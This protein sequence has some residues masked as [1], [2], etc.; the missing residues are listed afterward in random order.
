MAANADLETEAF[1]S[2]PEMPST[3]AADSEMPE[4]L[5]AL[6]AETEDI[7]AEPLAPDEI[8]ASIQ[9]VPSSEEADGLSVDRAVEMGLSDE[10]PEIEP[11]E[12]P[13]WLA[14]M[15]IDESQIGE[16]D[17]VEAEIAAEEEIDLEPGDLPD[18]LVAMALSLIHI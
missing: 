3:E 17:R 1:V 18:W 10:E 7:T 4:W 11:G 6:T 13:D 15:A 5:A 8:P 9:A 2:A 14:A 16:A 12:L